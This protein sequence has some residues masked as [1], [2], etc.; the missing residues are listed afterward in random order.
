MTTIDK[1]LIDGAAKHLQTHGEQYRKMVEA[2]GFQ[3]MLDQLEPTVWPVLVEVKDLSREPETPPQEREPEPETAAE[4]TDMAEQMVL[5]AN[6]LEAARATVEFIVRNLIENRAFRPRPR[7]V[8]GD[9]RGAG[10]I[11]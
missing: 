8:D 3:R 4:P 7:T 9:D 10:G 11:K 5:D 6:D 1:R 2:P